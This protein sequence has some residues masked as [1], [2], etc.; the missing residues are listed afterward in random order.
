MREE[1]VP[2]LSPQLV[3]AHL[4]PVSSQSLPSVWVYVQTSS[5]YKDTS[6]IGLG[7]ILMT[8]LNLNY[9]FEDPISKYGNILRHI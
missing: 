8:S 5:W 7:P 1:S 9:F 2:G 4:L 3:G 6:D